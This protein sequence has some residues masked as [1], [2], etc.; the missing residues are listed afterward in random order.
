MNNSDKPM[1]FEWC[2][3]VW[4]GEQAQSVAGLA[5]EGIG[6]FVRTSSG[7][8]KGMMV[9]AAFRRPLNGPRPEHLKL[10]DPTTS[11]K[12]DEMYARRHN[13]RGPQRPRSSVPK[14]V[15]NLFPGAKPL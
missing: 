15:N 7:S 14:T 2:I 5:N 11:M 13:F 6:Y 3:G 4:N 8:G 10:A 9:E 12:L 1:N